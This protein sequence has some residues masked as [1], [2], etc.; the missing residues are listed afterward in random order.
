M[1]G[2]TRVYALIA[3]VS[4]LVLSI[5]WGRYRHAQ[6]ILD[7]EAKSKNPYEWMADVSFL[8]SVLM[9]VLSALAFAGSFVP[10]TH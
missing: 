5:L 4:Y 3:L 2:P 6:K 8:V 9:C 7:K 1:E 10:T